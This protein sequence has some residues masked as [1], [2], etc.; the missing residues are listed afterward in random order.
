MDLVDT[1]V[2]IDV[3]R[4]HQAALAWFGS[5]TELPSV[6]GFVVMELIQDARNAREVRQMLKLVAPLQIIWPTEVDCGRAL[7]DFTAYHLSHGLGLLDSLI[8]ACALGRSATLC[9]FNVK[10]YRAIRGL[11]IAQPYTR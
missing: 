7:S 11:A 8:A 3:Q 9:T 6:P 2:L 10:H 1:D 5:L 4:G